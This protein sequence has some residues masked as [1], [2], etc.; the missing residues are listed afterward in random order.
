MGLKIKQNRMAIY[1]RGSKR[2]IAF[3]GITHKHLGIEVIPTGNRG[4]VPS[5]GEKIHKQSGGANSMQVV[6]GG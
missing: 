2:H 1:T 4:N 5:N 3:C 6:E